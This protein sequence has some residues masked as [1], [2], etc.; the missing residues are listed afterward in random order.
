MYTSFSVSITVLE[1]DL[2]KHSNKYELCLPKG[3]ETQ[4]LLNRV[5][6]QPFIAGRS[7]TVVW[8]VLVSNFNKY[9]EK[10]IYI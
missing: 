7:S 5:E 2:S 6:A 10:F 4:K 3:Y 8:D 1:M 9:L